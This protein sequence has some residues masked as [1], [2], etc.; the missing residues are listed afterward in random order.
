MQRQYLGIY[1]LYKD[2]FSS[3]EV[4]LAEWERS[5]DRVD[6]GSNP[7]GFVCLVWFEF[8]HFQVAWTSDLFAPSEG[9]MCNCHWRA[10]S[11]LS[12][13]LSLLCNKMF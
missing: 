10:K 12:V 5:A 11:R 4:T 8:L 6:Q 2:K 9:Y 7:A 1:T 13:S 3:Q